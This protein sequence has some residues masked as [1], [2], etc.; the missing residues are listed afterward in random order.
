MICPKN[1]TL[2]WAGESIIFSKIIGNFTGILILDLAVKSTL[3]KY[4]YVSLSKATSVYLYWIQQY[5]F[6]LLIE[7]T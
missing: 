5:T 3:H 2:Q 4:M 6:D 7:S 1:R